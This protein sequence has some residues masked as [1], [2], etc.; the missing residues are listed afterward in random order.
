MLEE[1]IDN[2]AEMMSKGAIT[3]DV[4]KTFFP[5]ISEVRNVAVTALPGAVKNVCVFAVDNL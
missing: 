1:I 4:S 5:L 2:V 3:K